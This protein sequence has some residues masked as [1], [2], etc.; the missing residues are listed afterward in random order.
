MNPSNIQDKDQDITF[1]PHSLFQWWYQPVDIA[2]MAIFRIVFGCFMCW[3]V[4]KFVSR[5][6]VHHFFIEP[7]FHL[8]FP[9]FEWIE[10]LP[11]DQMLYL[12]YVMGLAAVAITLGI[13][14]RMATIIFFLGFSYIFLL[15]KTL[16]Q[17]HY[18]LIGLLSAIMVVIPADR[19]FSLTALL[20]PSL[21]SDYCPRWSLWL[22]RFMVGVP[23]FFG[24][25][26][27]LNMDWLQAQPMLSWLPGN[28]HF[29]MI[30]PYV[31][32]P[33]LAW[34]IS[35]GALLFDLLV[36]PLLLWHRTRAFAFLAAVGF[37]VCNSQWF[38]IG[39]FPWFMI[40][41]TTIFFEPDWPRRLFAHRWFQSRQQLFP[42]VP[43]WRRVVTLTLLWSFVVWQLLM[44]FRH[45]SY[46]GCV[47]WTEEGHYFA[48]H[49]M[50]RRKLV[51]LR[52]YA[53][54]PRTGQTGVIQTQEFL[55][56]RQSQRIGNDPDMILQFVHFLKEEFSREGFEEIEIRVLAIASLN[57][58]KPQLLFD[59]NLDLARLK[60][61]W[62]HYNWVAEL[63]EPVPVKSWDVPLL[64]WPKALDLQP[65][66]VAQS[67]PS[68]TL[69]YGSDS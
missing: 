68:A 65:P 16:Y 62:G 55:I 69:S 67:T 32:Q 46:P 3:H 66:S 56:P 59:Q 45:L 14:Y 25:V 15:E 39:I 63:T 2:S 5:G 34:V 60:R 58:R 27:K 51:G 4:Y 7:K 11:G 23:Y 35:Y 50:L 31:D 42:V 54:D 18:Y 53:T 1:A 40:A 44:P 29:I 43:N 30:G 22:L 61:S 17:N 26:A 49:M 9:G 57:G 8:K 48:W 19:A 64:E 36:V 41:A 52:F 12:F 20:Q 13:R 6:W 28:D 37:H 24:G 21:R 33:W 47:S 38:N 10:P